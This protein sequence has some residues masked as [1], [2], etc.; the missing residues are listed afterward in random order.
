MSVPEKIK[1]RLRAGKGTGA[2]HLRKALSTKAPKGRLSATAAMLNALGNM[3]LN[4]RTSDYNSPDAY[5]LEYIYVIDGVAWA[6][7]GHLLMWAKLAN[8]AFSGVIPEELA[9]KAVG[10]VKNE[11]VDII[12]KTGQK[13]TATAISSMKGTLVEEVDHDE[14][15]PYDFLGLC[16]KEK[17]GEREVSLDPKYVEQIGKAA[18]RIGAH[19]MTFHIPR[20][21]SEGVRITVSDK[22]GKVRDDVGWVLMPRGK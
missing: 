7:N 9:K 1:R 2:A 16:P 11:L 10:L 4:S 19:S 14:A 20:S 12:F 6:C 18:A 3:A 22:S 15:E 21:R 17:P 8:K 13:G 5:R